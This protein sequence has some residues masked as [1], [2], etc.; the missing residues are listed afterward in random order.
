MMFLSHIL[1]CRSSYTSLQPFFLHYDWLAFC[2]G[3][4]LSEV[5]KVLEGKARKLHELG[6]GK[7]P[8][9][10]QSLTKEEEEMLW[11]IES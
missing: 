6:M 4:H 5:R 11:E 1:E 8:N 9:K 2:L 7:Q 10:A 3:K